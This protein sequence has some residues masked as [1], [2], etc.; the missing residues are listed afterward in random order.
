[1]YDEI[2]IQTKRIHGAPE[3]QTF[4]PHV[5]P[6]QFPA[7]DH[8]QSREILPLPC[9]A[10]ESDSL[11]AIQT[12]HLKLCNTLPAIR[13]SLTGERHFRFVHD[14]GSKYCQLTHYFG[15]ARF[16]AIPPIFHTATRNSTHLEK[17]YKTSSF[18]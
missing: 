16:P 12:L 13:V 14:Y 6:S 3:V 8:V 5:S 7:D 11:P 15:H 2:H 1:M 10:H 18:F 9:P 4:P 17:C